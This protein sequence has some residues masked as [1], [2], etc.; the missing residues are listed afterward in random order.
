MY[1]GFK[2]PQ[3]FDS[4]Y[5]GYS[6]EQIAPRTYRLAYVSL[7]GASAKSAR[8]GFDRT[9]CKLCPSGYTVREIIDTFTVGTSHDPAPG[10][11][12]FN[13]VIVCG[14]DI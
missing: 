8:R 7:P 13:G 4:S 10:G 3:P 2:S 1:W 11:L 14:N 5:P 6:A 9:A 12:G